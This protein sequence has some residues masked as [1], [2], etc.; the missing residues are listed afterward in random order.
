MRWGTISHDVRSICA[1]EE[2]ETAY[3]SEIVPIDQERGKEWDYRVIAGEK[4]EDER[5]AEARERL[6]GVKWS[7]YS[8]E[9]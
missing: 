2:I 6:D 1:Y 3:E 4:A 9:K 7:G 8:T 5:K